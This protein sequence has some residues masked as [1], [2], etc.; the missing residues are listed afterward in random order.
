MNDSLIIRGA[1]EHNLKG[2]DLDLPRDTMIVFTG[3]SG[4]GKSSLA[5]DTIFAEG[6]RRYVESLSSYARQFLGQMDKPDVELIEGLSPAVSIDQKST[7]RNPRSTVGTVTEVYDYL[8]LLYSRAGIQ[9]CPACDAVISSQTPQQIVDQ[10]RS[11]PEGTR[12]QVLAPVVRGR[13]GEYSELFG[14]LRGRGFNRVRVDGAVERLDTPPTLN[15]RLKH[16][17]E[18]IVDRLVVREGIRQRLTDS[19]E[20]ALG[21][22]EGLV[23]IEQVDL[24]DDDPERERRYSEK[25]ACPNEHPLAL[26]EMEPRTFSFNAPYGACPACTGIG[27]RLE[28][29]PELVVPDEELTLAEGAVAPWSSHQKYFTRQLEALGKELSFDVDTPWRALPA[30]AREAILRGKDYEV[31]VTYRNRWGRERIY[32]TGFEGVIDYVMRK[33]DETES[34]WSRER[35]QAYMREIP[36]PV[37][38]GARLKPEVLAVR[39]G[40]LSIAQL[41]ELPISEAR[42]FLAE[43]NLTGQAAQIAGSVLTE[44]NARLGFLVDVGLDYLSLARGAATLS[45]GEAQRIRLATQIG[46]GLV[47]VLYVLDEPSIGLH[48]R[49][50]TRLI[51]TLQRLRDLGN[52]LIVVEHD[53]DTIRSADWIVDIGPGAG[54][55]GGEVV[56]SGDV[57]G[58]AGAEGSVTGDYLARRRRI[59]IPAKRRKRDKSREVI[60]VGA[61]EN[62][63]KDVTVSF[64]LGVLTAVTGVSGSGKSSLVNSILYQVLANRLNR[65]RGVPGRHKTVRGVE[66]LDKVVHVDQSPIGRTPRSNPATYTG[67]W[68]HVRKIFAAV[69]ESKVRGYGPGRF[70]FN[71]KGGRCE[72]CRGD[73]TLKIEMNFLPDVY[74]PCEVCHGARYNRETLEIR[75][76]DKTVADVLDMT[77]HQAAD[78]FSASS[79]ISRHLNTLVEVGLGYVRLGQ[80]A[81]TLS[82][83]EA[84]RVKLATELQRRSTG[85]TIY[86]LDEPTTG[87][88]FEDIRKLLGVLQGLVDKGNSVVVIEHNLDVIANSDWVIDMGPEGGKGGGT[89]VVAG[90]PEKVAATDSSYTG[91][92]LAPMLQAARG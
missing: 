44:I 18:V 74:V 51:E 60:V 31:K 50:N 79:V 4:S 92:F 84:Q 25:R 12:F 58:L 48:Q 24:P 42:D 57:A 88:H 53:E 39:V 30:R 46:S 20:T 37:C 70:S 33:H 3:L 19:V 90:T 72:S 28:V 26:D 14:E 59:E 75:Y 43:L 83:G 38:D 5:F 45:G 64:P 62:N 85:R 80:S 13:K 73:G 1:R 23:I 78:F 8:R 82:G 41:C 35:Y 49:D 86:V 56:Y 65:A 34:D 40:G 67:V 55:L 10:V 89:V 61:R 15:K 66:H 87:L 68:D 81:T 17:I 2:V 63:L 29:D 47:G 32:S 77:I 76:K 54:E 69:P 11:L 21:L 27:T 7:S 16:D 52:T 22:A 36:C 91:R 6:Q 71:V 9:H